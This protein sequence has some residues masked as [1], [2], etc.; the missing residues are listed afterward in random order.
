MEIVSLSDAKEQGLKKYF[1]GEPCSRGHITF[2]R[3]ATRACWE[4]FKIQLRQWRKKNQTLIREIDKRSREKRTET[5][6]PKKREA[7]K[8]DYRKNPAKYTEKSKARR[9]GIGKRS[10][11]WRNPVAIREFYN[12]ASRLTKETG[13]TH[14]VDH[15]IP[16]HGENVSGLHV[17]T[18]LQILT[19]FE[20][21][22]K[23][24]KHTAA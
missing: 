7:S 17:E 14:E 23:W 12:L 16:L 19:K 9:I 21:R 13:I 24:N 18:N 15:V 22:R 10:P 3:V 5:R 8:R 20:N 2:R 6:L 11:L 1:T 4:C